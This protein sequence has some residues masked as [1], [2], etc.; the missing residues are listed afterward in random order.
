MYEEVE[1]EKYTQAEE[2]FVPQQAYTFSSNDLP[3][4]HS[5]GSA[6]WKVIRQQSPS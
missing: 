5:G 4:W 3:S 6:G 1:K 2:D